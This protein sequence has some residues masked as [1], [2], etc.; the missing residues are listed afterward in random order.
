[1]GTIPQEGELES[2]P[3][4]GLLLELARSRF[5]GTLHLTRAP[6]E[7]RF[8]FQRGAPISAESS[9]PSETLGLHLLDSGQL[10]RDAYHRVSTYVAQRRVKEGVALLELELLTP[11]QLF[12][13]L[14]EQM[15]AR[16]VDCFAWPRGRYALETQ[17]DSGGD[18]QPFRADVYSLVQEG[19]EAHWSAER[20]LADLAPHMDLVASG[21]RRLARVRDRLRRDASVEAVLEAVDGGALTLWR[22]LQAARTPR[23]MAAAWL[24][25][26]AGALDYAEVGAA[27]AAPTQ[28]EDLGPPQIEIVVA[29]APAPAGEVPA[30]PAAGPAPAAASAAASP[31]ALEISARYVALGELDHY[32]LLGVERDA[33]LAGIKAAYLDAAKR[34]HPDA[35]A[36]A[37]LDRETR[38]KA[39]RV[40]ASIGKAH[41]V[42]AD[43]KRRMKYDRSLEF[44]DS[45]IDAERLA[46]AETNFR[47]GEILM[48]AG[49]FR[50]ALDFLR[51]AVELWPEEP[52]YQA[53]L[54]WSLYKTR[55]SDPVRARQH[56]ERAYQ[57]DAR[58]AETAQ[59]LATVLKTL[60]E[61]APAANLEAKARALGSES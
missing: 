57:L 52:A 40:F 25:D 36:R 8:R 43:P 17:A 49:N 59:R 3:L 2:T 35:L 38:Q 54:G 24:L 20:V 28:I 44:D 32:A 6:H 23:A 48:R 53:A 39:G 58:N 21:N 31:L 29:G 46:A 30:A 34:Y 19:I 42:L 47:K 10:G 15:R 61:P 22:V 27:E 41:A 1:M 12:V 60:G 18:A 55:P 11:K 7:K 51:P 45:E 33:E 9:L 5:E 4:P 50:G 16:L 56:L 13:A 37:R 14:K 26:A